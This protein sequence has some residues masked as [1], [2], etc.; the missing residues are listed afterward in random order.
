[1]VNKLKTTNKTVSIP[2]CRSFIWVDEACYRIDYDLA[3]ALIK[4]EKQ[5]LIVPQSM[6]GIEK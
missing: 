2:V 4:K 6:L 5:V 3:K 1:M